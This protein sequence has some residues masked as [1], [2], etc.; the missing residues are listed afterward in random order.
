MFF[1]SLLLN[2]SFFLKIALT[3][4]LGAGHGIPGMPPLP[5]NPAG[6]SLPGLSTPGS[7]GTFK[8]HRTEEG[9]KRSSSGKFSLLNRWIIF[10]LNY[11]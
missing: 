1:F 6:L 8:N 3:S 9:V 10:F 7:V 5:P 2:S 4:S 11:I